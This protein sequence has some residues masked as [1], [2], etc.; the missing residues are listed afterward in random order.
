[1]KMVFCGKENFYSIIEKCGAGVSGN[2]IGM[3]HGTIYYGRHNGTRF[4]GRASF[5]RDG[6][7][8]KSWTYSIAN[9]LAIAY[10]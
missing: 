2:D 9:Y 3:T 6:N 4:V 10:A 1:M 5:I 7:N 8:D